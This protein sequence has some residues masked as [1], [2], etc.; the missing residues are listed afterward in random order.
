MKCTVAIPRD[1]EKTL[2]RHL[3]QNELEQGAF[4]FAHVT[5][6]AGDISLEAKDIYLIPPDGWQVQLEVY[7]E[8]KDTERAKIMKIARDADFAVIDCHSHP[9]S[10]D[11][12]WF[13]PSD[14]AGISDFALYVKWKLDG[15]PYAAMVWGESSLDAVAWH[16]NFAEVQ[17]VDEVRIVG[18]SSQILTPRGTWFRKSTIFRGGRKTW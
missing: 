11:D 10:G 2:R 6:T 18:R 14:Q 16:S 9:G 1:L 8:M 7:L 3:F 12:V 15:K 13:S 4:L 17:Q 5:A